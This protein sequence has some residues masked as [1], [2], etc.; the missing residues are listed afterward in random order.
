LEIDDTWNITSYSNLTNTDL[1]ADDTIGFGYG[2]DWSP[3]GHQLVYTSSINQRYN[4]ALFVAD[5][6]PDFTDF[7]VTRITDDYWISPR[8]PAWRPHDNLT[9]TN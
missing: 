4:G 5:L 8:D 6:G 3:D 7:E 1:I 2:L 9:D